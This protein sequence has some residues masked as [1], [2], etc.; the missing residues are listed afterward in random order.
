MGRAYSMDLR[1]RAMDRVAAGE[2]CHAVA[3]ALKV[4]PSVERDQ[5]GAAP[6]PY[7][8]CRA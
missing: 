4:A 8:Q 7:R 3:A 6:A 5:V 2:T 1:Q